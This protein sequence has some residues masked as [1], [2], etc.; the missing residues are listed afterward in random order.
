MNY[1]I[2]PPCL[3]VR[4][5]VVTLPERCDNVSRVTNQ[6]R[7]TVSIVS[8]HKGICDLVQSSTL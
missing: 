2:A 7:D 8:I 6:R 1:C 5:A 4:S 3:G